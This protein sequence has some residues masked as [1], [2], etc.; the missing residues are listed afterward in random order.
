MLKNGADYPMITLPNNGR[1]KDE[2]FVVNL[3]YVDKISGAMLIMRNGTQ[4]YLA[5]TAALRKQLMMNARKAIHCGGK[6]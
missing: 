5:Q 3:H 4:V 1:G 6:D 2:S